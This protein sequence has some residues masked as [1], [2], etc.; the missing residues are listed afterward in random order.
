VAVA[1]PTFE[2]REGGVTIIFDVPAADEAEAVRVMAAADF[3]VRRYYRPERE[4]LPGGSAPGWVR[5]GAERPWRDF[6]EAEQDHVVAAFDSVWDASALSCRR[7]GT[8]AWT[9]GS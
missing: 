4:H 3:V 6:T 2:P 5:L 7:M 1:G 8:D 9:A